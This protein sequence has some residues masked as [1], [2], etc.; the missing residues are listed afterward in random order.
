MQRYEQHKNN[1]KYD[2]LKEKNNIEEKEFNENHKRLK[3]KLESLD[4]KER[5]GPRYFQLNRDNTYNKGD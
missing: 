1:K 4:K 5:A 3:E 2:G